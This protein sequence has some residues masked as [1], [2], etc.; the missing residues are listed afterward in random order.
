MTPKD[1]VEFLKTPSRAHAVL[2]AG[3]GALLFLPESWLKVMQLTGFRDVA[4]PYTGGL[5]LVLS[6]LFL[7][8]LAEYGYG[9]RRSKVEVREKDERRRRVL[10]DLNPD[11]KAILRSFVGNETRGQTLSMESGAVAALQSRGVITTA[12]GLASMKREGPLGHLVLATDFLIQPWAERLL[13]EN[14]SWID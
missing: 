5:F 13:K 14:P 10:Q 6:V 1:V 12:T 11:E 4:G 9:R 8:C 7:V 3:A 2:W